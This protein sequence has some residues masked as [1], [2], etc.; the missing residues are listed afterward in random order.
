M[1]E[2]RSVGF[3]VHSCQ[4]K[5]LHAL[6]ASM[7]HFFVRFLFPFSMSY[8]GRCKDVDI[9]PCFLPRENEGTERES[10]DVDRD[11]SCPRKL[12]LDERKSLL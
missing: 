11:M 8:R 4:M 5:V 12:F 9:P 1:R 6:P 10:Q 3:V 2:V 7:R